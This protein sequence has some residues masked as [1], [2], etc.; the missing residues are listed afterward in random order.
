MNS[1]L[2]VSLVALI[3]VGCPSPATST[4]GSVDASSVELACANLVGVVHCADLDA[5][6]C[7]PGLTN[8]FQSEEG[9]KP[10]LNCLIKANTKALVRVCAPQGVEPCL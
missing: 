1:L 6:N 8:L 4:L 7:V 9:V 10:D 5:G 3:L 2:K